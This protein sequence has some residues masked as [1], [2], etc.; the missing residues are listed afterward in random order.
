LPGSDDQFIVALK[1]EERDGKAV[2]SYLC[3]F[4][5]SD[6]QFLIEEQKFDGPYKFEGLIIY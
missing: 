3:F 6:G 1:S 5:L 2:A 4:R